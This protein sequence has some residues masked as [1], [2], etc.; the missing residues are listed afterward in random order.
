MNPKE[1]KSFL[2]KR[3]AH[4]TIITANVQLN[5][6]NRMQKSRTI[7]RTLAQLSEEHVIELEEIAPSVF[8]TKSRYAISTLVRFALELKAKLPNVICYLAKY[9]KGGVLKEKPKPYESLAD[10]I[11]R[12]APEIEKMLKQL[13]IKLKSSTRKKK[14]RKSK[15]L[16]YFFAEKEGELVEKKARILIITHNAGRNLAEDKV[17]RHR[18]IKKILR[19]L[20]EQGIELEEIAPSI[21]VSKSRHTISRILKIYKYLVEKIEGVKVYVVAKIPLRYYLAVADYD[22]LEEILNQVVK[23][24]IEIKIDEN[25]VELAKKVLHMLQSDKS[26]RK[27]IAKRINGTNVS[28]IQFLEELLKQ[29]INH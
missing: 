22:Y 5:V 20:E 17:K 4:L 16:S 18:E 24:E 6:S 27:A 7:K 1:I 2:S 9:P 19:E 11:K 28:V 15:L 3:K 13:G 25:L 23:K 8:I 14:S 29:I 21:Y 26:W 10:Y 12:V